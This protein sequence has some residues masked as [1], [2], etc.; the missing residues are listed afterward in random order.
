MSKLLRL[1]VFLLFCVSWCKSFAQFWE[2]MPLSPSYTVRDLFPDAENDYLHVVGDFEFIDTVQVR[3]YAI[4]N[5]TDW[6]FP[7]MFENYCNGFGSCSPI[8][9]LRKLNGRTY[10]S[11]A[12]AAI[13]GSR[14]MVFDELNG[15]Q[16]AGHPNQLGTLSIANNEL[17]ST[18]YF[19]EIDGVMMNR[20]AR[21]NGD[22]WESFGE[23][24][25][26]LSG[27]TT[28]VNYFNGQYYLS[29]NYTTPD[30]SY[31]DI[32]RW[33]GTQWLPLANG[34][35]GN[36][37]ITEAIVFNNLLY[38]GG[39]FTQGQGNIASHLMAWNGETWLNPFPG[40]NYIWDISSMAVIEG[41][42]FVVGKFHFNEDPNV[43]YNLARFDGNSFCAFG[44]SIDLIIPTSLRKI[45]GMHNRIYLTGGFLHG[46]TIPYLISMPFDIE[47]DECRN[48]DITFINNNLF[49]EDSFFLHPNPSTH[50]VYLSSPD[51]AP[52]CFVR[53]F[54]LSGQMVYEQNVLEQSER[55][56][57]TT[58]NIGP[59][60]MY[61]VQLHNPGKAM[62]VQKLVVAE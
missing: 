14:F 16:T 36:A 62:A 57:I 19:T 9:N 23:P 33:D 21:W 60:G 8:Y 54:N 40:V 43:L 4:W 52:G 46:E 15:W 20:I 39:S 59:P 3:G 6:I 25:N 1:F 55:M 30:Q 26:I 22:Y 13:T 53:V 61:V 11:G 34:I 50:T 56:A 58:S 7:E 12:Y 45:Q 47:S 48:L 5:G 17:F 27:V 31:Y 29:G 35:Y 51:L 41:E 32:A 28:K 44:G 49:I 10:M 38:I 2:P 18:G 24:L 37:S 42:L